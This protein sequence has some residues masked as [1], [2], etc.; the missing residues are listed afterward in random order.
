MKKIM[1]WSALLLMAA[2]WQG[3]SKDSR[4][5]DE[6][7][8]TVDGSGVYA[9][10]S[11][12]AGSGSSG[13][14]SGSGSGSGSSNIPAGQMTAGEWNDLDN[15]DFWLGLMNNDTLAGY[16][17]HWQC[18]PTQRYQVRVKDQAGNLVS[19]ARVELQQ[20]NGQ[21]IWAARTDN[22]G[23]AELWAGLWGGH[24]TV[25]RLVA[26]KNGQVSTLQNP[27]TFEAG[28]NQ[29]SLAGLHTHAE[30]VE[31]A[32]VVDATGSMGDEITY[33][34]A[35]LADVL[36]RIQ[37]LN[38]GQN[39]RAG[40]IFYRDDNDEYLTRVYPM[41]SQMATL[42]TFVQ[43]QEAGGGGDF[44]EAVDVAL[45]EAVNQLTWSADARARLVFL[46]LDAP[47]HHDDNKLD[48][49]R[50]AT[51]MA[52]RKG[53]KIIPVTASGIDKETE[54]LM[55]YLAMATQGTYVFI[56]NHSGLG[57]EHLTAT[58]GEYEV[59]YLNDLLVRLVKKYSL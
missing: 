58:V 20:A 51:A 46:I 3:C 1:L 25:A 42:N 14:S 4:E 15:W 36:Q 40:S 27:L 41:G 28:A 5:V 35:E 7:G 49:L 17:D 32:F 12:V 33:L 18:F 30:L 55:R 56:T 45:D 23:R 54:F 11:G 52:A 38:G 47:P 16:S 31:V 57:G 34:Q 48:K 53:I 9:D 10:G 29:L 6:S 22:S 8:R 59:E 19:D 44:P 50:E 37:A 13:S 2:V 43:A 21:V 39:L 24:P 26:S